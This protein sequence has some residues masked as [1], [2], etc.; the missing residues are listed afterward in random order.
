MVSR[1]TLTL[2]HHSRVQMHINT[3]AFV[4]TIRKDNKYASDKTFHDIT[5]ILMDHVS[6]N[7]FCCRQLNTAVYCPRYVHTLSNTG[8]NVRV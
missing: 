7:L 6:H 1:I 4:C 2:V 5:R 8:V 3:Q